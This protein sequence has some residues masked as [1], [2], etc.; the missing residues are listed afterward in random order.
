MQFFL[1]AIHSKLLRATARECRAGKWGRRDT[2][3]QSHWPRD[4]VRHALGGQSDEQ[5][6]VHPRGRE[7]AKLL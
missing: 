6:P 1:S 2:V 4:L 3:D 5:Q 7:V